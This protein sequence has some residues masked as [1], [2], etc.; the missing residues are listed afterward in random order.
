MAA[1]PGVLADDNHGAVLITWETLTTTNTSGD[2]VKV[3]GY[4]LAAVQSDGNFSGSASIA[5]Q[6]SL[7]A[8]AWFALTKDGANA[9]AMTAD[10]VGA[11]P[12][13]QPLYIRPLLSDGNGSA[14]V[15]TYVLLKK[16]QRY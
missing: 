9:I 8:A 16:R 7:N 10:T 11:K 14:D 5:L 1:V 4:D 15:D 12:Y 6:G 13:E 2:P 3:A